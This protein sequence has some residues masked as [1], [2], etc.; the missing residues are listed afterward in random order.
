MTTKI[1][2]GEIQI[3][4]CGSSQMIVNYFTNPLQ[5]SLFKKIGDLILNV[6][7]LDPLPLIQRSVLGHEPKLAKDLVQ[8]PG[9]TNWDP[10]DE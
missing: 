2:K 7:Q 5:G 9:P 10:I 4:H 8:S 3:D 6:S 1:A